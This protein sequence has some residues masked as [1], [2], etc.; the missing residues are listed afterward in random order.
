MFKLHASNLTNIKHCNT[1]KFVMEAGLIIKKNKKRR[2]KE[3]FVVGNQIKPSPALG[4]DNRGNLC[5]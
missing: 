1:L 5:S 3:T 4:C 2:S